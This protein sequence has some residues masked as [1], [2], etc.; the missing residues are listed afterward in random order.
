MEKLKLKMKEM[1]DRN[2]ITTIEAIKK[3]YKKR[4][5]VSTIENAVK[6]GNIWKYA[7]YGDEDGN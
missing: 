6:E 1:T 4:N 7:V 2:I 5:T 3:E